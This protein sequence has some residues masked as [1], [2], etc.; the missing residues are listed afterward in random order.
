MKESF[1]REKS[2]PKLMFLFRRHEPH[3]VP[4]LLPPPAEE[5]EAQREE[6][7]DGEGGREAQEAG[8]Q[9]QAQQLR[10]VD[11]GE[12]RDFEHR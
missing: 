1:A 5:G 9:V 11:K 2:F 3:P 7:V 10:A 6:E 8:A 4:V 12:T